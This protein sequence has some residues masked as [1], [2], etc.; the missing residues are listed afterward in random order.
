MK[1][2][3]SQSSAVSGVSPS[4][5]S[6]GTIAAIDDEPPPPPPPLPPPMPRPPPVYGVPGSDADAS[7]IAFDDVARADALASSALDA[8]S[9]R[10]RSAAAAFSS[11]LAVSSS[12]RIC[13]SDAPEVEAARPEVVCALD[14]VMNW[15]LWWPAPSLL[16]CLGRCWA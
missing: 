8:E 9:P 4:A 2:R 14:D 1:W 11:S 13:A 3:F 6:G 10:A 16:W 7:T 5:G 15:N 12:L